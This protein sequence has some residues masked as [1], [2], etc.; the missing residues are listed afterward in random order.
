MIRRINLYGGS[1]AGKSTLAAGLFHSMKNDGYCVELVRE[2]VKDWA[3][4]GRNPRSYDQVYLTATQLH[5]EDTLLS[6]SVDLIITDSPIWLGYIYGKKY[7]L[8]GHEYLPPL[9]RDFDEKYTSVNFF[10]DR[11]DR[12]Y[13][14]S[15]RFQ[16]CQDAILID[17]YI[18]SCL[19]ELSIGY[20]VVTAKEVQR[21]QEE[22]EKLWVIKKN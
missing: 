20:G 1:G 14:Q 4:L 8:A 22:C 6:R 7:D 18:K 2:H 17:K 16:N 9:I 5:L 13:Q 15:G 3:Y 19:S 12:A 11:G 10:V 21:T